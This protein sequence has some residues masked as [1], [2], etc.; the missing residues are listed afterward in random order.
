[1]RA[2]RGQ[3]GGG[4]ALAVWLLGLVFCGVVISRTQFRTD[5]GA[6]LPRSAPMAEQVLTA[7]A[8]HGA[9]SHLVLLAISGA[10]IPVLA[11]LSQALAADLRTRPE[12]I[13]VTNGGSASFSGVQN[14]IWRNRYLL[15][16]NV[17]AAAFSRSGL[18]AAL[19][20]DLG[21]LDSD[22]GAFAAQSIPADPTGEAMALLPILIPG[23]GPASQD[24]V[25]FSPDGS[26]ALLLV[27]SRAPGF[28][29]D[30]QQ[31]TLQVIQAR[32]D[33][34]SGAIP[35]AA[36][37]SLQ[38]TGPGV[39]AVHTRDSTKADV[40]RLS[41]LAMAGAIGLLT[42]AYRSPR[43]LVLGILP[44]ATGALAAIAS[45]SLAF[46]FVHGITLGFG[47]TLIG[48]SLDYA[49]YLFTQTGQGD[50]VLDTLQRIWPTLRLGALTSIAGFAAM[51][52]SDFTG[53]AQL[54]L[55]SITGL[56]AAAAV[57]RFILPQLLPH[58]F[59]AVALPMTRPVQQLIQHRR[60]LRWVL[61]LA[62]AAAAAALLLH[63]GGFWDENLADLSPIPAADARLDSLLQKDFGMGDIRYFA[64][65]KAA[66]EQQALRQSEALTAV[67]N[68]LLATGQL[69]GF[70][71]PSEILPSDAIQLSRRAA[72][73]GASDLRTRLAAAAAGLPFRADTFAPFLRD[74]A[75]SRAAPLIAAA[76]L[77]PA[78]Q[79][80]LESM[81][82]PGEGGWV[83]MAPLDGVADPAAVAAAIQAAHLPNAAF[84]DLNA[85]STALLARFQREAVTLAVTGSIAILLLLLAG[86]RSF[87][88]AMAVAAP[89]AGAVLITFALLTSGGA[90]ISIFIV[91]GMLLIVAVGSNYCLFFERAEAGEAIRQRSIA[92]IV[93]ANLCTVCAYGLLSF[94][95]MP[96]LHDIGRTVAIGTFLSLICAALLSRE[97]Q[98]A[99]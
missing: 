91:V 51:L 18:H 89:L 94:S 83:V 36:G 37:A 64:V 88:R 24:G 99:C 61:G 77:P 53:F 52:F 32:F 58:G 65:T 48:E 9:A 66:D 43:V 22:A 90:K 59:S 87:R 84:V 54:G 39:F 4:L 45:V 35:G 3:T 40:T 14:F 15:S 23:N 92:S 80:H 38:M 26:L 70:D 57:T 30:G 28:D 1:M 78:L 11:Q 96:V 34:A 75:A 31:R 17:T 81:L 79:L 76:N 50:G 21:L 56:I 12:F 44:V 33:A 85:E 25:W 82:A 10:S 42:F 41:L 71:A 62:L 95:N 55:F 20:D 86:L 13:D 2:S 8:T 29:L 67:L 68:P 93:L 73:P 6:F 7:Q 72:L 16:P 27:H 98:P 69:G 97:P 60:R 46:G 19:L 47:V 63:K 49:I 74:A 5:M